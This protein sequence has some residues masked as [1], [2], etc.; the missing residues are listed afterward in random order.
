MIAGDFNGHSPQWGYN[1][2]NDS[3]RAIE[4]ICDSS[5]LCVI[6]DKDS[7]PTLLHRAHRTLSRPDLTILSSDLVN[8]SKTQV[9]DDV[10]SDHKPI[11]TT[12]NVAAK[13]SY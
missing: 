12:I 4:E 9:L 3:G 11:L 13:K 2:C 1:G 6:Q 5:N 10:G 8:R 7:T